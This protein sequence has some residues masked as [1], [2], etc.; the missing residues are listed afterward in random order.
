MINYIRQ[1]LGRVRP[2]NNVKVPTVFQFS[3]TECGIAAL[4][5]MFAYY[6]FNIP[7]ELLRDKCGS[8]RDGCKASVLIKVAQDYGFDADAYRID[9]DEIKDLAQPVIAF[10]NFSHYVVINGIGT[11]RVFIN[12]PAHGAI[13]VS[14]DAFDKAF[15]GI[16]ISITPTDK[17]VK[18]KNKIKWYVFFIEWLSGFHFE[19]IFLLICLLSILSC[20]IFNSALTSIFIDQCIISN[21]K[22]LT[23]YMFCFSIILTIL[24]IGSSIIQK[25]NQ[26]KICAYAGILKSS[27]IFSHILK[28]PLLFYS[29][30]Q[31]SEIISILI[32]SEVIVNLLFNNATNAVIALITSIMC[33]IIMLKI[34]IWLSFFSLVLYILSCIS[35]LIFS[36]INF[37]YEKSNITAL[38]RLYSHNIS[39]IRN[40][41]TIKSCGLENKFLKKWYELFSNKIMNYDR[42]QKII[43]M[44][45]SF[46]KFYNS[47]SILVILYLGAYRV[48]NGNISIGNL[49]AYYSIYLIFSNSLNIMIRALN[50]SQGAYVSH[51]RIMDIMNYEKD[52]R[53]IPKMDCR[54]QENN[55]LLAISCQDL[56]FSYNINNLP[57]LN[58]VNFEIKKGEHIAFV[59]STGSGKSTLAKIICG[60]YPLNKGNLFIFGE[61]IFAIDSKE[62]PRIF[63]YVSQDVNLFSGTIYENITLWGG[64]DLLIKVK[65]AIDVACLSEFINEKGLHSKV[66]ENGNNLSGGE[67]QRIEIARAIVQDTPILILDEA[68]SALDICTETMLINNLRKLDKTIIFVAHRLSTI[69]HCDKIFVMN[70]GVITEAGSHHDLI[71]SRKYYFNLIKDE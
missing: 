22:S 1:A 6:K 39:S 19:F 54:I 46:N 30:R 31:K 8:G 26:F 25:W 59:G 23:M 7:F 50:D 62:F 44:G 10:W 32:R 64:S 2:H 12:D 35:A 17:I 15:T 53:F 18:T 43:S 41:E 21:N 24:Y 14:M 47:L 65:N 60:L 67:K 40:L 9:L 57:T 37:S 5:M 20:T 38:G 51:T 69:K 29:L 52:L 34:D 48:S 36:K 27:L 55:S 3:E 4:S 11:D 33:F 16:I 63:S 58:N 70:S 66:G 13:S 56:C 45:N 42:S 68:T 49:V 61:P 71:Q 28:L